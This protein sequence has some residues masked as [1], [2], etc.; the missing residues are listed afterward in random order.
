VFGKRSPQRLFI[1]AIEKETRRKIWW[2]VYTLDRMLALA[3]GRPIGAEDV[4]CD[5]EPPLA[6][7]D[8]LLP[9]FFN[10]APMPPE[11]PSLMTG[12]TSLVSLYSIAGR[13]MR[14]V[15]GVDMA[16]SHA[17][18][19]KRTQLQVHVDNLDKELTK[20]L[21]DLPAVFKSKMNND[22]QVA[23]GAALCSHYYSVLT[24][25]H[26]N[27]LPVR[28]GQPPAPRS[29]AKAVSSARTCIRLA[30][31]IKNV[32]PP[33]HHLAFFIQHLFS[34]AVIIL[35]YAMH[36]AD[37][38]AANSAMEEIQSCLVAL[39]SFEGHW[40]G[41]QKVKEL[42]VE[43]VTSSREAV[44][45]NQATNATASGSASSSGPI[46]P[47]TGNTNVAF[48]APSIPFDK[49]RRHSFTASSRLVKG[50]SNLRRN[51][52]PDT[53]RP[54]RSTQASASLRFECECQLTCS[55]RHCF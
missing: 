44:L 17:D 53:G 50:K 14:Q 46:A 27:L 28:R 22:K 21:D 7:D 32:V 2:G 16:E 13:V 41:A 47:L 39:T 15:Y 20:W 55:R 30:P 36:V 54:S 48:A 51:L 9:D 4:D 52:S 19:E 10:G 25:L 18:P 34:S 35:L 3:L 45:N 29:S 37:P 40:P 12:F 11:T 1:P 26:R 33:S 49:G 6:L 23:M 31:F 24:A 42:L 8:D 43:L 5:V 38:G